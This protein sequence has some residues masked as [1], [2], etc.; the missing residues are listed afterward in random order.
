MTVLSPLTTEIGNLRK[1]VLALPQRV[2]GG[3]LAP[4][5]NR[6][7][8]GA[9]QRVQCRDGGPGLLLP[10]APGAVLACA[11][12]K[13]IQTQVATTNY[14]IRH[15]Q[16]GSAPLIRSRRSVRRRFMVF[17]RGGLISKSMP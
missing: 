15:A 8:I 1:E 7:P 9:L 3:G 14:S 10:L 11:D 12:D 6:L 2:L 13:P 16:K 5:G 17:T 4:C